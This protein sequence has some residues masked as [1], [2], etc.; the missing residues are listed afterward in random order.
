MILPN[1]YKLIV[2]PQ[3]SDYLLLDGNHNAGICN[4]FDEIIYIADNLRNKILR[5]VVA[6]ELTHAIISRHIPGREIVN[7]EEWVCNF[8]GL[9][10]CEIADLTNYVL[11]RLVFKKGR[12]VEKNV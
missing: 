12:L 8:M 5:E 7:D 2:V 11:K 6:H 9:Y 4:M 10:A 3:D 1:K